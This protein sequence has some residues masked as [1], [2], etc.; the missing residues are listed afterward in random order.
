MKCIYCGCEDSKVLDSRAVDEN[1]AIKRR[2]EC[3]NCFKRFTTYETIEVSPILVI[4]RNGE[5]QAFLSS[6]IKTGIIKSCEKR[7][8]SIEQIDEMVASIEQKVQNYPKKEIPSSELGEMVMAELEKVDKVS[9]IRFASVYKQFE[10][11]SKFKEFV[12]KLAD[13]IT[14]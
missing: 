4:K 1:N 3:N 9:Y 13:D 14:N 11:V 7:P 2:R 10:D 5:R 8:V 6:K 12:Q